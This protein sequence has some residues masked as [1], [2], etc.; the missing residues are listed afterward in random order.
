M[1]KIIHKKLKFVFLYFYNLK[2]TMCHVVLFFYQG[3]RQSDHAACARD[4][5]THRIFQNIGAQP[6][7][8]MFGAAAQFFGRAGRAQRHGDRFGAADSRH[9]FAIHERDDALSFGF[10]YHGI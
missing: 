4:T 3:Y 8:D 10:R 7:V 2:I 5:D 1:F 9:H 6:H